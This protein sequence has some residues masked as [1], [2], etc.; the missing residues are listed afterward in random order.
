MQVSPKL[1]S[2]ELTNLT[3]TT[4]KRLYN[5]TL[6]NNALLS[7]TTILA[8]R[9][10]ADQTENWKRYERYNA[11]RK[12]PSGEPLT[13]IDFDFSLKGDNPTWKPVRVYR[14][15]KQTL[16]ELPKDSNA[17][18]I[19]L[20]LD[21]QGQYEQIQ[22]KQIDNRMII[23]RTFEQGILIDGV[24]EHQRRVEIKK[25]RAIMIF[26]RLKN[27]LL[28]SLSGFILSG[29]GHLHN[30]FI[31]ESVYQG[32]FEIP[33][34]LSEQQAET[35]AI[36]SVA[37]IEE[38]I[39]PGKTATFHLDSGGI[40]GNALEY[41]LRRSGYPLGQTGIPVYYKLDTLDDLLLVNIE[42]EGKRW[43]QVY[44][45]NALGGLYVGTQSKA[46]INPQQRLPSQA[47]RFTSRRNVGRF[48]TAMARDAEVKAIQLPPHKQMIDY[49]QRQR[50]DSILLESQAETSLVS[51]DTLPELTD[52]H[53]IVRFPYGDARH[54]VATD[55][56]EVIDYV[57]SLNIPVQITITGHS[58]S[59]KQSA[60]Q[61]KA[62]KRAV[63]VRQ[64]LQRK[65]PNAAITY[66]LQSEYSNGDKMVFA[67]WQWA[68]VKVSHT[69]SA[70]PSH[71]LT[72]T[73]RQA[74]TSH[75]CSV[76]RF[77]KGSLRYAIEETLRQC[78]YRLGS[79]NIGDADYLYEIIIDA[80]YAIDITGI[81][82]YL[83][84]LLNRY[85]IVGMKT[86][87]DRSISFDLA[88]NTDTTQSTQESNSS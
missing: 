7:P 13:D 68:D 46:E 15:G 67:R 10:P 19:F 2:G 61:A 65:F 39:N 42:I 49:R 9:Y 40:F 53:F 14:K 23:D 20:A 28:I 56:V 4:N 37:H 48:S 70:E 25:R 79:W 34:L 18:P 47:N 72:N 33:H 44:D 81:D 82:D 50:T 57:Q 83:Q 5:I 80:D 21:K 87:Y 30:P 27:A 32:N 86:S 16:I 64:A 8:F 62:E 51:H 1:D 73:Q 88:H 75:T 29:C 43:S 3:I 54:P 59:V 35:L 36:A 24:G 78:G 76:A 77:N 11:Q 58:H 85:G 12:L 41:A 17:S 6:A 52:K 55:M 84:L 45:Q 60:T 69:A 74:V 31:A 71:R 26:N 38:D 66:Q 63:S 22:Y